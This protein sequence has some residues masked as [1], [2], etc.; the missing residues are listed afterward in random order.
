[1]R[2]LILVLLVGAAA[3][4]HY[5]TLGVSRGASAGEIKKAYRDLALKHHPDRCK[6]SQREV[7]QASK[8]FARI[9]DAYNVL[10]D[11]G[12][13]R[14][15]DVQSD[16][17]MRD[18]F[19]G[20]ADGVDPFAAGGYGMPPQDP[21]P[22]ASFGS[23]K[24][25]AGPPAPA[26]RPF[27]CTLRDLSEGCTRRFELKD[28]MVG[29]LRDAFRQ[30]AD[31]PLKELAIFVGAA[32][33][34]APGLIWGRWWMMK[35]PVFIGAVL[36]TW[37]KQLPPMPAGVFEFEVKPGWREG[38]KVKYSRAPRSVHFVLVERRH[39]QLRR[40][41]LGTPQ[42]NDLL[43]DVAVSRAAAARGRNLRI[44]QPSGDAFELELPPGAKD[45][46]E[47]VI[48]ERGM[49]SSKDGERGDLR[50]RVVVS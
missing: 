5:A 44:P 14:M 7:Q 18:A 39:R 49:P 19:G 32:L 29:R 45:G 9:S 1:M 25:A 31:G 40:G 47:L 17:R 23:R 3:A 43:L 37:A 36:F 34:K 24:S 35:L 20:G 16:P 38:T 41:A 33:W 10:S 2:R 13:R 42:K 46:D 11:P 8:K 4:N 26:V 22:F 21:F 27:F 6:G 30:G 48:K 15:Y 50:V 12:K 28:T